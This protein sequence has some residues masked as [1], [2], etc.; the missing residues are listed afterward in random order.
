MIKYSTMNPAG[1]GTC[2]V[3]G[4]SE[5]LNNDHCHIHGWIRGAV[6]TSC[7]LSIG[8]IER[9]SVTT[10]SELIDAIS[11]HLSKCPECLPVDPETL[12]KMMPNPIKRS[13]TISDPAFTEFNALKM[14][15]AIDS[16]NRVPAVSDL[17]TALLVVGNRHYSEVLFALGKEGEPES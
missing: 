15:V 14:R 12:R 11:S 10:K 7:N 16:S 13:L 4:K 1:F 17:V 8:F 9:Q 6:C 5:R 2:E 3:C